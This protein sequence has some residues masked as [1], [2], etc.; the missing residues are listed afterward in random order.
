MS[1][2]SEQRDL[3]I[4]LRTT[5]GGVAEDSSGAMA[6][7]HDATATIGEE[8]SQAMAEQN[9][10][11]AAN[12]QK[13]NPDDATT[14]L[15]KPDEAASTT[16][17]G[18]E[19]DGSGTPGASSSADDDAAKAAATQAKINELRGQGH[20]PQR[21]LD[22]D[23]QQLQDR[24]G[25]PVVQGNPPRVQMN[26]GYVV[27]SKKI[28]PARSGAGALPAADPLKYK[29]MYSTDAAGVPRNHKC[30]NYST[31]FGD[32]ESLASA[33]QAGRASIPPTASG[34]YVTETDAASTIGA[35]GV[36]NLRGKYIDPS[37]PMTGPQV[38]YKNVNFTGA[39]I[40]GVYDQDPASGDWNLTTMYPQPDDG[41]NP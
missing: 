7:F 28:D 9:E 38:N 21:H 20:A 31:A 6:D 3:A 2:E 4:G 27:S 19:G 5:I 25:T 17:G 37:N 10:T 23:D 24:L 13:L 39:K 30:G 12:I 41:V 33:D 26:S 35:D 18:A 40:L 11:I 1:S 15:P 8:T 29:D 36:A 32:P 16:G 34:H 22:A 14:D